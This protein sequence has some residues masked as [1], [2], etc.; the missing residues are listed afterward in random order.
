MCVIAV[1]EKVILLVP[2]CFSQSDCKEKFI[3]FFFLF[4]WKT[5]LVLYNMRTASEEL[6]GVKEEFCAVILIKLIG[7][8]VNCM[9]VYSIELYS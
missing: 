2:K 5:I 1:L 8:L 4:F 3:F 9:H 6:V 7:L